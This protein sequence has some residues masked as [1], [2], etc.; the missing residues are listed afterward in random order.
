MFRR[1]VSHFGVRPASSLSRRQS[2]IAENRFTS[3]TSFNFHFIIYYSL[4]ETSAGRSDRIQHYFLNFLTLNSNLQ[5]VSSHLESFPFGCGGVE[6]GLPVWNPMWTFALESET[7][8]IDWPN[9]A[10]KSQLTVKEKT[11]IFPEFLRLLWK[12]VW[13]SSWPTT[14]LLLRPFLRLLIRSR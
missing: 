5:V 12:I 3:I 1:I 13:P 2:Y 9:S 8:Q 4:C 14:T 7:D 11:W 6:P 10:P